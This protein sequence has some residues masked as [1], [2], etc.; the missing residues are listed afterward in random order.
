MSNLPW[1]YCFQLQQ[2]LTSCL[3][4][5]YW[6]VVLRRG[7]LFLVH[8][9]PTNNFLNSRNHT[10]IFFLPLISSYLDCRVLFILY[11]SMLLFIQQN[12]WVRR[13]VTAIQTRIWNPDQKKKV[14]LGSIRI[15]FLLPQIWNS[16]MMG[17]K[18]LQIINNQN[19]LKTCLSIKS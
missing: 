16:L 2:G 12:A 17:Q 1:L 6:A 5:G 9:Q 10:M 3:G 19:L 14:F 11:S 7:S 8:C 4:F 18:W 13:F 15:G